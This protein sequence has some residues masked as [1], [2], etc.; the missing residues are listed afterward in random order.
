MTIFSSRALCIA[1]MGVMFTLVGCTSD[2]P[3]APSMSLPPAS[4]P[5]GYRVSANASLA[6]RDVKEW[7][8]RQLAARHTDVRDALE[9]AFD[10]GRRIISA[11]LSEPARPMTPTPGVPYWTALLIGSD[12]H[13][14]DVVCADAK[15]EP[16]DA[17]T[18]NVITEAVR[19]WRFTPATVDGA[20]VAYL[21]VFSVTVQ[22][23]NVI[24]PA[25]DI[26]N[27]D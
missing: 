17:A 15:G 14:R 18:T 6:R 3:A 10:G 5:D 19:M 27:S 8:G 4:T 11:K 1:L 24:P 25:K 13:V 2:P 9:A 7:V 26:A 23:T 20:V 21:D 16:A 22:G 12:G